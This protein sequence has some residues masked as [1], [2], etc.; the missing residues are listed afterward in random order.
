MAPSSAPS[1]LTAY[2]S[3]ASAIWAA[4]PEANA[5]SAIADL[6]GPGAAQ[7]RSHWAPPMLLSG[8]A[9]AIEELCQAPRPGSRAIYP[10]P[11]AQREAVLNCEIG[12]EDACEA[13]GRIVA[14]G[15]AVWAEAGK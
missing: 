4:P 6:V 11:G 8:A 13:T 5:R 2:P 10:P 15:A 14:A 3:F 12:V 7:R 1:G 9:G